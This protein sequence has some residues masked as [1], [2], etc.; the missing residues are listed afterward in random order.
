M[1][2]SNRHTPSFLAILGTIITALAASATAS[3]PVQDYI[4]PTSNTVDAHGVDVVTGEYTFTTTEVAIG[5]LGAGGLVHARRYSGD[6]FT[7]G[8]RDT[9]AGTVKLIRDGN[10]ITGAVVS[11][12]GG[13]IN[14][15]STSGGGFVPKTD[16]SASLVQ[17][18]NIY[19]FTSRFGD[20]VRFDNTYSDKHFWRVDG[21]VIIDATRPNGEKTTYHH[22]ADQA[23]GETRYR[24]QSITNSYGYMIHF[25]YANNNAITLTQL[26]G[27]WM[28]R[29]RA[30]GINLAHEYCSTSANSCSGLTHSWPYVTYDNSINSTQRVTNALGQNTDYVFSGGLT[31]IK[32]HSGE[33]AVSIEYAFDPQ[34]F[35]FTGDVWKLTKNGLMQSYG[36]PVL[37]TGDKYYRAHATREAGG[38]GTAR[39]GW[40]RIYYDLEPRGIDKVVKYDNIYQTTGASRWVEYTRNAQ[41]Q[42]ESITDHTGRGTEYTYDSRGNLIETRRKAPGVADV[43]TKAD[44]AT[45]CDATNLAYCN[46]P[47]WTQDARGYQT[48]YTYDDHGG[49]ETITSPAPT[50]AAPYGSGN[51]PQV[52]HTYSTRNARYKS[53]SSSYVDGPATTVRT[54]TSVCTSGDNSCLGEARETRTTIGFQSSTSPNNL[55]ITSMTTAAG[56]GSVSSTVKMGWD[57]YARPTY[58]DG[59]LA[60]SVD[61]AHFRHDVLGRRIV[62]NGPDPD[63]SSALK[64][65]AV[66]TIYDNDGF[67][68][69]VEQGTMTGSTNW[70][71]FAALGRAEVTYDSH[72]RVIEQRY[73]TGITTHSV[74]QT[75]YDPAGRVECTA[76]RMDPTTF[77]ALPA[78]ACSQAA[79]FP[80]RDRVTKTLYNNY[81]D[82]VKVQSGVGT[83]LV[84]DTQTLTY[85]SRG[86]VDTVTDAEG[87]VS[88]Y[89]YDAFGRPT[90]IFYPHK[91]NTGSYNG[92]DYERTTYDAYGRVHMIRLRDGESFTFDYDNLGRQELVNSSGSDPDVSYTYDNVSRVLTASQTNGHLITYVYDALGRLTSETG[93]K[94]EVAYQ[95]NAAGQ[96]S[97]MDYPGGDDFYVNYDYNV[98]GDLTQIREKGATSGIGVLATFGYDDW[99]RRTSLTRG[100][101]VVTN[102]T[103]DAA[104]RLNTLV[105]NLVGTSRDQTL[106]FDYNTANQIIERTNSNSVYDYSAHT[107]FTDAYVANGQNQYTSVAG[108]TMNYDRR[109][110][111]TNDGSKTY[112]YDH[113][114]RL[115]TVSGG[116]SFQYDPGSRLYQ[117]TVG[118]TSTQYLY[119]GLDLIAE[120]NGTTVLR[121]YVH[122][123]GL[124]EPLVQYN[125]SST[126]NRTFLI[127]DERGSIV[128]GTNASGGEIYIN[129]YDEYGKPQSGNQGLFQYTGQIYLSAAGLYHYKARAYDPELGRFLQT[130]PIGYAAGMNLYSYVSSDPMNLRDP[131][132]LS[133]EPSNPWAPFDSFF[134]YVDYLHVLRFSNLVDDLY[135]ASVDATNRYLLQMQM[136]NRQAA[137]DRVIAYDRRVATAGAAPGI[138]DF[139]DLRWQGSSKFWTRILKGLNAAGLALTMATLG[140]DIP[141]YHTFY[142]GTGIKSGLSLLNGADL[143]AS[144]ASDL[145]IDG[146]IGFY[147]TDNYDAATYFAARRQ[148]GVLKYQIHR[149]AMGKLMAGGAKLQP[150]PAGGANLLGNELFIPPHLFAV[151]NAMRARGHIIVSSAPLR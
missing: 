46:Q 80:L 32:R 39:T 115:K 72:G 47:E 85:T 127:A 89:S 125:G 103:F 132:G 118:S 134:D 122:G 50:G 11:Y 78:S 75:S 116:I 98:A 107:A 20:V 90:F 121:R 95:Y 138:I 53:G 54:E 33:V 64:H 143:D 5:P 111:L 124:D 16:V 34:N 7:Q 68:T 27:D 19:T 113:S 36:D 35:Q 8:W 131:F 84:Q 60:G 38:V 146:E 42:V 52:R 106:T 69:A 15:E 102:Y 81:D 13:S 25:A 10:N 9:H 100:N 67:V 43:V 128:A 99:G 24:I 117:Q 133:D 4:P 6:L 120:Y 23:D 55:L 22:R 58:V 37:V 88:K 66:H 74:I 79:S 97:R 57:V 151:F 148:G 3:A 48:V 2:A 65:R 119:D 136:Q 108:A 101:N 130:D 129:R 126:T 150:I 61:R 44:Y 139:D 17:N 92:S 40:M 71:S 56:N 105:N 135:Q 82:V 137:A 30:T 45:S 76:Y 83:T 114:N 73:K 147:L 63:G 14:F 29:T 49:V 31:Q 123:P 96:R 62:D 104:G 21:A 86:E 142:H 94:G 77:G 140:G 109:G 110:N 28:R 141:Q 149:Y 59:P 91:T 144:V 112:T 12:N 18:G 145:H 93:P 70:T 87:N 26:E 51:R 41:A 1:P